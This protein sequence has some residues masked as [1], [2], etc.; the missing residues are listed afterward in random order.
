MADILGGFA[1]GA[2]AGYS[3]ADKAKKDKE[4]REFKKAAMKKMTPAYK[5]GGKVRK[6]KKAKSK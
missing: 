4:D 5:R 2:A 3:M 1:K 6:A